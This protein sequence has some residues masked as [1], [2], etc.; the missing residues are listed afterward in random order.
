MR[1]VLLAFL[2]AAALLLAFRAG[3]R[4]SI[5]A[6]DE[7]S[8]PALPLDGRGR[9]VGSKRTNPRRRLTLVALA[10]FSLILGT[11]GFG[12]WPGFASHSSVGMPV[13]GV[14]L[15]HDRLQLNEETAISGQPTVVN[16]QMWQT[17]FPDVSIIELRLSFDSPRAEDHWYVV[18]SGDYVVDKDRDLSLFCNYGDGT[19]VGDRVR[20]SPQAGNPEMEFSFDRELGTSAGSPQ[21]TDSV[22]NLAGY[23]RERVT[24]VEGPMPATNELGENIVEVRLPIT[25][26]KTSTVNGDE[27]VSVAPI[28]QQPESFGSGPPLAT[29]CSLDSESMFVLTGTCSA[30]LPV[31]VSATTV[32]VNF[33]M[34][35]RTVEYAAPDTVS[36]D[37]VVWELESG[38]PGAQALVAD[39]FAQEDEARRAFIA[40]LVL[41]VSVSSVLLF[42]ERFLFHRPASRRGQAE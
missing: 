20:C 42:V 11:I 21:A 39:P 10:L 13:G 40:A 6:R 36:D 31:H 30:V 14:T 29:P 17:G 26:P 34:G 16:V 37:A 8:G 23:D 19:P 32:D 9:V 41:S 18:A 27:F 25:T 4:Q 35:S 2:T 1:R 5:R 7:N 24:V 38:F 15:L 28:G 3:N 22:V 12:I 33:E